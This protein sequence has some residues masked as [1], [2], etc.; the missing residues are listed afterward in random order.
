M[1]T[2]FKRTDI[3]VTTV[4]RDLNRI[5]EK[6][7]NLYESVAIIAK[8][9]NQ[10]ADEMKEELHEK[11]EEFSSYTDSF[12]DILENKEQIEVSK[13]Y[14]KLPKPWI[15]ATEEFLEG[16]VYFRNPAKES[17]GSETNS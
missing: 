15:I 2:K 8:R 7:G 4:T 10:I 5:A 14:E 11:L 17:N 9:A 12:D 3:P 6:T 1:S 16:D 13:F